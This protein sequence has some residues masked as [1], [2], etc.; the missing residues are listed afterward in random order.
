[1]LFE[2]ASPAS[3][4]APDFFKNYFSIC[5]VRELRWHLLHLVSIIAFDTTLCLKN[6]VHVLRKE[7]L[8]Y[9]RALVTQ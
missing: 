6:I 5:E 3:D 1:M 4:Q 2:T 7:N 9:G 8:Q